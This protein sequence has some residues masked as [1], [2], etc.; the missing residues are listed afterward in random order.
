MFSETAQMG[1]GHCC[2]TN[3]KEETRTPPDQVNQHSTRLALQ[4]IVY[5]ITRAQISTQP[6]IASCVFPVCQH[7][8]N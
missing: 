1:G 7:S 6:F 2:T 5:D 4:I 3:L 8:R